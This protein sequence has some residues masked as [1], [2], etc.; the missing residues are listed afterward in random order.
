MRR[1]FDNYSM[2]IQYKYAFVFSVSLPHAL[3]DR[4]ADTVYL[5]IDVEGV[6]VGIVIH[7]FHILCKM[8]EI[9]GKH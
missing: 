2:N 7:H 8:Q 1:F 3:Y 9:G 5:L 4:Q 6:N